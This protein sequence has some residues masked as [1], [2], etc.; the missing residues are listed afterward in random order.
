M[1]RRSDDGKTM[2]SLHARRT[3][4][5]AMLSFVYPINRVGQ[6][7]T[8]RN[9]EVPEFVLRSRVEGASETQRPGRSARRR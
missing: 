5:L 8:L 7:Y 6:T 3:R 2:E 1:N 9:V 4:L